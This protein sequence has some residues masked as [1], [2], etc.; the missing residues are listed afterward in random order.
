MVIPESLMCLKIESSK[1]TMLLV[2]RSIWKAPAA[3]FLFPGARKWI[4][5]WIAAEVG[6]VTRKRYFQ[7]RNQTGIGIV[8]I[9]MAKV[10]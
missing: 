3:G 10:V 1:K 7:G 6:I 8:G 4:C 2:D 9:Q 5:S